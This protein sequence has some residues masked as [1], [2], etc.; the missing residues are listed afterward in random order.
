MIQLLRR[1]VPRQL[2]QQVVD[3]LHDGLVFPHLRRPDVVKVFHGESLFL[4]DKA[5][6]LLQFLNVLGLMEAVSQHNGQDFVLLDPFLKGKDER[7]DD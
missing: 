1:E 6:D 2:G 5:E 4:D 7:Y 3:I